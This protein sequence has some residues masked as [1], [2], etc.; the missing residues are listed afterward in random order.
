MLETIAT[1]ASGGIMGMIGSIISKGFSLVDRHQQAKTKSQEWEHQRSLLE[2]KQRYAQ[3]Q[4]SQ[5][6][7]IVQ[8]KEEAQARI[9]SYQHDN[10]IGE[11]SKW[12]VNTLRL[13]RPVLTLGLILLTAMV[14]HGTKNT[15]PE[16]REEITHTILF[17][18]TT[19]LTWWFGDRAKRG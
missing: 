13:V 7:Q 15:S 14:W 1:V 4:T 9:H 12:V 10:A 6:A 17:C 3:E 11:G 19:A 8:E 18:A 16:L 2:L 5:C